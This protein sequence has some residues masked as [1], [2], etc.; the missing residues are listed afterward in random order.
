MATIRNIEA[1]TR[2]AQDTTTK[3]ENGLAYHKQVGYQNDW[4]AYERMK[5]GDQWPAATDKTRS[6][7]RPVFNIIDL[8][9]SLKVSMVMNEQ[10]MMRY[11]TQDSGDP[12]SIEAADLFSRYS[13]TVWEDIKQNEINE[14]MLDVCANVGTGIL[15]YYWDADYT[16]GNKLPYAGRMCGEVL[17]PI[18]VFFGNPQNK[19][20]QKQP[21][22]IISYRDM[23]SNVREQAKASGLSK[24]LVAMIRGDSDKREEGYDAAQIEVQDTE[25]VTVLLHYFR[26]GKNVFF[27][28]VASGIV[29]KPATDTGMKLYPLVVM[30]WKRRRKSI[31]GIGD[32]K[33]LI[34]NQRAINFLVAMSILSAQL[35]GWPKLAID[36]MRVN[37]SKITNTPGEVVEVKQAEQGLDSAIKFLNPGQISPHVNDLVGQIIDLTRSMSSANES[38]TGEAPGAN[39][40]AAAI[41]QL[42]KANG[43]PVE[44]VK[45]RF[46]QAME[47]VGRVWEQFFKVKYNMPREIKVKDVQ[48]DD[49]YTD[50]LGTD[51]ADTD[52]SLK[53]DI[54]PSSQFSEALMMASLDKFLDKQFIDFEQYLKYAPS[55]VVPFKERLLKE[56]EQLRE[57]QAAAAS[58]QPADPLATLPPE[59]RAQYDALPPD[60]QQ[61]ILAQ[62]QQTG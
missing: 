26:K 61:A 59:V 2:D 30:Q 58:Q 31:H 41:M 1:I 38:S 49:E 50:F 48:G 53:I 18:N 47:D 28:K 23:L 3:Y 33:G 6:L 24:T 60:Q 54:G 40:A 11:S 25:K 35:T 13:D 62:V 19:D 27:K 16:G 7:P 46:Y 22:I 20:V 4:P 17:D 10:I 9:E 32:T 44:S 12:I 42:Q 39:M 21:N 15:H 36:P 52:L 43:V 45:R 34:P 57:Q 29:I 56:M 55:N 8:I 5:A 14:E 37:K 51:Y